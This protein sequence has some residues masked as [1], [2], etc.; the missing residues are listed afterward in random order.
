[1]RRLIDTF[2]E[3]ILV[4]LSIFALQMLHIAIQPFSAGVPP[5]CKD[6]FAVVFIAKDIL[7][8]LVFW[9]LYIVVLHEENPKA[10]SG[11]PKLIGAIAIQGVVLCI[12]GSASLL[13]NDVFFG[14]C[15]IMM[16][17][18]WFAILYLFHI[19]EK[20]RYSLR[21]AI[22]GL[23]IL[24]ALWLPLSLH[25][26]YSAL[27]KISNLQVSYYETSNAVTTQK[28]NTTFLYSLKYAIGEST[29][30][31]VFFLFCKF[32]SEYQERKE[33]RVSKRIAQLL[34]SCLLSFTAYLICLFVAPSGCFV[35]ASNI[36]QNSFKRSGLNFST[37]IIEIYRI[38][39][40]HSA[41]ELV[42]SKTNCKV[43]YD[44][45]KITSF[46]VDGYYPAIQST[47]SNDLTSF[48]DNSLIVSESDREVGLFCNHIVVIANEESAQTIPIDLIGKLP[49]NESLLA[50][51][52][53][54]VEKNLFYVFPYN[55]QYLIK[56]DK[57][58]ITPYLGSFVEMDFSL[59]EQIEEN[60]L[61]PEYVQMEAIRLL[62]TG[63]G[64][65]SREENSK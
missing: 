27:A 61:R 59:K 38:N 60:G 50:L 26:D 55:A 9:V 58:Y 45:Q 2:I 64:S 49:E 65:P 8:Y 17:V 37:Q 54:T 19:S 56:W 1:M 40:K 39:T 33:R 35:S 5:Y 15:E 20:S 36:N 23:L 42:Y 47:H 62:N 31:T 52:R 43:R 12:R 3:G 29:Y 53:E 32:K 51:C 6:S 13:D 24:T 30:G 63:V 11:K 28:N 48:F 18:Q 57:E 16:P 10:K 34:L 25:Y 44:T 7:Y 41:K 14:L 4:F 21:T 46:S 22:I